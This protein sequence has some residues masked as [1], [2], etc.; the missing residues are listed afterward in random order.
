M[1]NRI[2]STLR[3]PARA[4]L[5]SAAA[6]VALFAAL[7]AAQADQQETPAQIDYAASWQAARGDVSGAYAQ[8]PYASYRDGRD[9]AR[10]HA[11]R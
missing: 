3:R 6:L 9:Y 7:P 8:A 10:G 5:L 2:A 4:A 1:Q 11:N